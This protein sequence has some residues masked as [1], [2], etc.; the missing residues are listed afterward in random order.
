MIKEVV[1]HPYN[2]AVKC[3]DTNYY[4][5]KRVTEALLPFLKLSTYGARI[6]NLS[7]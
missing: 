1:L 4:G 5:C 3:I 7:P 6:V 2:E